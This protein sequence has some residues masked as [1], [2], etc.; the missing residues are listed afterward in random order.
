MYESRVDRL[1]IIRRG[2]IPK[3]TGLEG[4][5]GGRVGGSLNPRFARDGKK[6]REGFRVLGAQEIPKGSR[7]SGGSQAPL[8]LSI[9]PAG[10]VKGGVRKSPW[11]GR[12]SLPYIIGG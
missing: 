1:R 2:T 5:I 7:R 3:V 8:F 10:V 6:E 9:H 4:R 12:K 11:G